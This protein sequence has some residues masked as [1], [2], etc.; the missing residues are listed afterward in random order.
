MKKYDIDPSLIN[1]EITETASSNLRKIM[2]KNMNKLI[3]YG[4]SFSLD[5]FGMGNSNLNYIIE[6]PVEIIK[7]DRTLVNSYFND[8][9]AKVV[10]N[11]VIEMI[12]SL[13]FSIVFEGI[14][15]EKD[16]K[17][18][19]NIGIDYIQGYYFSKPVP[20]NEFIEFLKEHNK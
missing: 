12:K 2:L 17:E 5:D 10:F 3:E 9:K 13:N 18:S 4:V 16:F 11:K 20:G 7:F 1:L 19:V 15:E 8:E 14:E 6:M